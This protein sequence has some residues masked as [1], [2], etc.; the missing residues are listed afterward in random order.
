[1]SGDSQSDVPAVM[2]EKYKELASAGPQTRI[3]GTALYSGKVLID[4]VCS[5]IDETE[6]KLKKNKL[7]IKPDK[8]SKLADEAKALKEIL[9]NS[10]PVDSETSKPLDRTAVIEVSFP[11]F[12]NHK[13]HFILAIVESNY[14]FSTAAPEEYI[15]NINQ[16]PHAL[17][18]M[19][20]EYW[21]HYCKENAEIVN[22]VE[23]FLREVDGRAQIQQLYY[24]S[25]NK[26]KLSFYDSRDTTR[27]K[28]KTC[29]G[30]FVYY[31]QDDKIF[32]DIDVG[33]QK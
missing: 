16:F 2:K 20:I 31:T 27:E 22:R 8:M 24:L 13:S 10:L 6:E 19:A 4:Y 7:G 18:N 25:G 21:G 15:E 17:I 12:D 29:V 23:A 26:L 3:N 32:F 30:A 33:D 5:L 14:I 9:R 11:G 1:M 28:P